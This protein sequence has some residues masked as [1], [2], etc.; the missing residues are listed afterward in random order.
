[1]DV[2]TDAARLRIYIG[3]NDAHEDRPLAEALVLKARQLGLAGAT[4][5]RGILG[6]GRPSHSK[7]AELLLL[8]RDEPILIERP[9]VLSP[10]GARLCRPP[11]R[12]LEIL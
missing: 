9:V 4:A 3:R 8:S 6:Y 7:E 1:M 11:E 5:L 2:P 10:K 12:V